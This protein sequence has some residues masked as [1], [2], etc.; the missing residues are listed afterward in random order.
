M[1]MRPG[2]FIARYVSNTYA[3]AKRSYYVV[4]LV[5]LTSFRLVETHRKAA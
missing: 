4:D 5:A 1:R 2:S 3:T